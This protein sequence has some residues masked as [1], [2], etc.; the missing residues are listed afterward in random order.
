MTRFHIQWMCH[1]QEIIH[2]HQQYQKCSF[3]C[4]ICSSTTKQTFDCMTMLSTCSIITCL[5]LRSVDT[6][7]CCGGNNYQQELSK[8][9][10]AH[11]WN[12]QMEM[13][14]YMITLLP[15]CQSLTQRKW[16][17][18][19]DVIPLLCAMIT[20]PWLLIFNPT[21]ANNRCYGEIHTG[22]AWQPVR[23][24]FCGTEGKYMPFPVIIFV[25]KSHTDLHG[26]L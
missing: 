4:R 13:W 15:V 2:M 3:V 10:T 11:N 21:C 26:A 5:H 12:Q 9:L 24:K 18:W 16:Y 23:D 14:H 22:D 19:L 6:Q 8:H 7:N 25:D 1:Q 17:C 20:L